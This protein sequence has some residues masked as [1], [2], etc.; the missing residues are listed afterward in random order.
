ML[1]FALAVYILIL[2][3]AEQMLIDKFN[4]KRENKFYKH[5]NKIHLWGEI[6]IFIAIIAIFYFNS[7]IKKCFIPVLL[8]AVFGF[9]AFMEW[10][11]DKDSKSYIMSI[12]S[13]IAVLIPYFVLTLFV[14]K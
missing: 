10:K 7:S 5:V 11:Y 6:L 9:R 14:L 4:I 1:L 3:I 13:I 8:T 12:F 2:I